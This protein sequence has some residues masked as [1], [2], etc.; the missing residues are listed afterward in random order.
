[1]ANP[2]G[3]NSNTRNF[4]FFVPNVEEFFT[5]LQVV[6]FLCPKDQTIKKES[7]AGD[8]GLG[9][10]ITQ[11]LRIQPMAVRLK[12]TTI[13]RQRLTTIPK[14]LPGPIMVTIL[15]MET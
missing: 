13:P 10:K 6:Q 8:P 12:T 1:L 14:L 5:K 15:I 11:K 3:C 9:R 4:L 2:A 7:G